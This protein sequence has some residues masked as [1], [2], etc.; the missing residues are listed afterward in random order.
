MATAKKKDE[1]RHRQ[2]RLDPESNLVLEEMGAQTNWTY[3]KLLRL[4][5]LHFRR[6]GAY[7]ELVDTIV[8]IETGWEPTKQ[9]TP[10]DE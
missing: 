5:I 4:A 10:T 7:L 6:S 8:A 1:A 3:P 9:D 2:V